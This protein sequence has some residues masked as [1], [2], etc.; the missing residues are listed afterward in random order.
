MTTTIT[1]KLSPKEQSDIPGALNDWKQ[2]PG[3]HRRVLVIDLDQMPDREADLRRQFG[4][5]GTAPKVVDNPLSTDPVAPGFPSMREFWTNY[6]NYYNPLGH[7]TGKAPNE[8]YTSAV[9]DQFLAQGRYEDVGRSRA[10]AEAIASG[11]WNE[12]NERLFYETIRNMVNAG[13]AVD[14]LQRF[15]WVDKMNAYFAR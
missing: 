7:S 9:S 13:E 15:D 12:A 5:D 2:F 6:F 10:V 4:M 3:K 1:I 14:V 8:I 11:T